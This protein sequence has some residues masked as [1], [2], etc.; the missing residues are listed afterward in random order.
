MALSENQRAALARIAEERGL[1]FAT[2]VAQAEEIVG[3]RAPT[4]G[5][6]PSG[7]RPDPEPAG[8][9]ANAPSTNTPAANATAEQPKLFMYLL[10]FV[11]VNEVRTVWLGREAWS[12]EDGG[13]ENAAAF[14]ARQSGAPTPVEGQ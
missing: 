10:P 3:R 9:P 5:V 8:A 6:K 7:D 1:D 11:T 2:L 4:S 14:A 13:N 12:D